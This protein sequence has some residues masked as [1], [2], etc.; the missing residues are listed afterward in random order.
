MPMNLLMQL[1]GVLLIA[2]LALPLICLVILY[3]GHVS[4]RNAADYAFSSIDVQLKKRWDLIPGLVETVKGY[5]KHE[6]ELFVRVTEARKQ[7]QAAQGDERFRR[8]GEVSQGLPQIMALAEGY[9]E[10]KADRQ[11]LSLQR[12]LTEVESQISAARR[13]YNAAITEYNDGV[14]MFPSSIVAG[15]F[16]FKKREWFQIESV[17]RKVTNVSV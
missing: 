15:V 16:G 14:Q 11:F 9:P 6:K 3:N 4:R 5:A 7:A 13:A 12:N 1:N 17:E 2:V 8:E 10:L